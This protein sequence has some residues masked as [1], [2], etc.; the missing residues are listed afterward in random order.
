MNINLLLST[1][2]CVLVLSGCK[3]TKRENYVSYDSVRQVVDVSQ[4]SLGIA[5]NSKQKVPFRGEFTG[6]DEIAGAHILYQ[7][8]LIHI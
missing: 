2:L 3:S 1:I 5:I 7:L 6:S 4:Q 8:S